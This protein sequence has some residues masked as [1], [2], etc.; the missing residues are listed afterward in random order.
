MSE[1]Q[2]IRKATFNPKVCTYWLLS[3]IIV[4]T[5]T[6]VGI[7]FLLLWVPLGLIF[8]GR[9]LAKMEC[10]LTPKALKVKKGILVRVEKTIP[11]EKI[12]DM[13]MIQGPV[14]RQ[15]DLHTL[16]VET[17][18]QSGSGSLVSLTGIVDAKAFREAVLAQRDASNAISMDKPS[19]SG[20]TLN[21][22][23]NELLIEIRDSLR[24]L[25]NILG[26][27]VSSEALEK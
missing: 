7:P 9:Y 25:E 27:R 16:T 24:R 23:T 14:M 4:M 17:A 22:S 26:D 10:E 3:G 21:S 20:E 15:F 8:T 6:V 19:S 2:I 11:L 18:G 1:E 12:T 13:G 5:V